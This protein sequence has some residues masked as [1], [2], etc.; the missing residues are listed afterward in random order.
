MTTFVQDLCLQ[1]GRLAA[2]QRSLSHPGPIYSVPAPASLLPSRLLRST[3]AV[4]FLLPPPPLGHR[5]SLQLTWT[6]LTSGL[7]LP[8]HVL[9][10]PKLF[11]KEDLALC[12]LWQEWELVGTS[13]LSLLFLWQT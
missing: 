6:P 11:Q 3:A 12:C 9:H 5:P 8:T 1:E 7:P 10:T 2:P 13:P 4:T